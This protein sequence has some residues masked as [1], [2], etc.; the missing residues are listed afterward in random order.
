MTFPRAIPPGAPGR[1]PI[2][3]R[4]VLPFYVLLLVL[5][6]WA[7]VIGALVA[8]IAWWFGYPGD[9]VTG[10]GVL[11]GTGAVAAFTV[12]LRHGEP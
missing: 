5:M 8:G 12:F 3:L 4:L 1:R 9:Q 7:T 10:M 2:R 6:C 11:A